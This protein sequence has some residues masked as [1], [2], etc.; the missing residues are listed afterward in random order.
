MFPIQKGIIGCETIAGTE[1]CGAG[2]IDNPDSCDAS[3]IDHAVAL[4]G[5]GV[6]A[7]TPYWTIKNSWTAGW[8]EDG[9]YRLEKGVNKCGVANMVAH[10]EYGSGS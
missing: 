7:G 9:Y 5:Y 2:T 3:D 10:S 1:Y 8:G 6:D 4:V